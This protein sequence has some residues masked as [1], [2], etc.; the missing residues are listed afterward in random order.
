MNTSAIEIERG[1]NDPS[2]YVTAVITHQVRTGRERGYEEWIE[3]IS[4]AARE[5]EG[6]LGVSILRPQSSSS[7]DY[8]IVLRFDTCQHL[9]AWLYSNTRKEWIER[10]KPLTRAQESIQ[11]LTGLETWFQLPKQSGHKSPKRYK[12]AIL[13]WVGVMTVSLLVGPLVAP[14]LQA[15][16]SILKVAVNGAI[17][18][19]LLSYIVMPQL[20]K[21]FKGW[22]FD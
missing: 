1:S 7:S 9:T 18:V 16:P 13:V 11:I 6:H 19:T 10:V 3:G 20:T 14:L 5:F 15:L 2:Q 17:T 8:V 12:Q 22:L 4:A 21:W